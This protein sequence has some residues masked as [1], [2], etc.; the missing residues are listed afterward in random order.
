[1]IPI[2][3]SLD[4]IQNNWFDSAET[5]SPMLVENDI[6]GF[7]DGHIERAISA[8]KNPQLEMKLIDSIY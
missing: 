6:E 5:S 3:Y 1:M 8:A 4:I 7:T 2:F